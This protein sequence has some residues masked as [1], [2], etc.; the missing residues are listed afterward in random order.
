MVGRVEGARADDAGP[1]KEDAGTGGHDG[2]GGRSYSQDE[3]L[4]GSSFRSGPGSG[5]RCPAGAG[6]T[7]GL[8]V[9]SEQSRWWSRGSKT[10]V[11]R[12]YIG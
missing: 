2:G 3:T 6:E 4:E 8:R 10:H 5:R 11:K 1:G 9:S 12:R 7:G